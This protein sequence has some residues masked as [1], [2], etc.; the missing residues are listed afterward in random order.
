MFEGDFST[1]LTAMD[2]SSR[3]KINKETMALKDTLDEMDHLDILQNRSHTG[4]QNRIYKRTEII[5]CT[6]SDH[7]VMKLEINHKKKFGKPPNA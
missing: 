7:N 6:F 3:Q 4:S 2:I 5:P 1:P